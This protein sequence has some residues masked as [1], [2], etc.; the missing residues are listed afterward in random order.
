MMNRWRDDP[1]AFEL[2]ITGVV[3]FFLYRR[4]YDVASVADML[5]VP[6]GAVE[7]IMS[8]ERRALAIKAEIIRNAS[9]GEN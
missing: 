8:R 1:E 7:N 4:I 2:A 5:S 6:R 9:C 3:L